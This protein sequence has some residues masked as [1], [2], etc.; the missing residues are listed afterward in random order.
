MKLIEKIDGYLNE[1]KVKMTTVY[2]T[3]NTKKIR[4][5]LMKWAKANNVPA[6]YNDPFH[7]GL[8]VS[9]ATDH[10]KALADEFDSSYLK[11]FGGEQEYMKK[12]DEL[13]AVGGAGGKQTRGAFGGY[14]PTYEKMWGK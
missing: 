11:S 10:I 8:A 9:V 6:L 1:S 4:D 12:K 2:I 14:K 3:K 7:P 13:K 5:E